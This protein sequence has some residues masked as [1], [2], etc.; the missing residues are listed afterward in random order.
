MDLARAHKHGIVLII[1]PPLFVVRISCILLLAIKVFLLRRRLR[2]ELGGLL[3]LVYVLK[4]GS[5]LAFL[6]ISL[7]QLSIEKF[8]VGSALANIY[9]I[10][11]LHLI[12]ELLL[13]A[14][15]H[16][17]IKLA[18]RATEQALRLDRFPSLLRSIH[19]CSLFRFHLSHVLHRMLRGWPVPRGA[20]CTLH[21]IL[22]VL[23]LFPAD[24]FIFLDLL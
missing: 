6:L 11:S 8:S 12:L 15:P 14:G 22:G 4:A 20:N 3:E 10:L 19:T 24:F 1:F 13:S 16:R 18:F 5:L 17:N 9:I 23:L 2:M 21:T 7:I